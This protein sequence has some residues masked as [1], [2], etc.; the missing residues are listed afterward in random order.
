[1]NGEHKRLAA[2]PALFAKGVIT[3]FLAGFAGHAMAVSKADCVQEQQAYLQAAIDSQINPESRSTLSA[4]Y[5]REQEDDVRR[6]VLGDGNDSISWWVK[7]TGNVTNA[8]DAR[9]LAQQYTKFM[10]DEQ[11]MLDSFQSRPYQYMADDRLFPT[12]YAKSAAKWRMIACF[13]QARERELSGGKA[14][15]GAGAG[16]SAGKPVAAVP[17]ECS[18]QNTAA[19]NQAVSD[20]DSQIDAF[21]DSPQGRKIGAATPSLQV[22]MWAADASTKI[23]RRYCPESGGFKERLAELK[24]TY[25][26]AM[27]VCRTIQ[28]NPEICGPVSPG[29]LMAQDEKDERDATAAAGRRAGSG[30]Q[31]GIAGAPL[32]ACSSG[33]PKADFMACQRADC[34]QQGY[35]PVESK[36][37]RCLVCGNP[38]GSLGLGFQWSKCHVSADGVNAAR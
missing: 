28:G 1:M 20:I 25:D 24:R 2:S 9:T 36:D 37:G 14:S 23:I 30:D 16:D 29:K 15:A 34:T 26:S 5:I 12:Q 18:T 13:F 11:A 38:E 19:A 31:K 7:D 10:Q 21:L 6:F 8:R 17:E 3:L 32:N 33:M 22:V 35:T 27:Q 4:D